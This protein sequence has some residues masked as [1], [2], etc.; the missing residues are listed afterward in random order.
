MQLHRLLCV[1][2]TRLSVNK[3]CIV[4]RCQCFVGWFGSAEC[5]RG[6]A[7]GGQSNDQARRY[8]VPAN[9][10]SKTTTTRIRRRGSKESIEQ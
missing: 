4:A 7:G 6:N 9:A 1:L 3:V 2:Q 8:A 10:D 5:G